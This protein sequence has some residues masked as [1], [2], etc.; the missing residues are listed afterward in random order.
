MSGVHKVQ[1]SITLPRG[2]WLPHAAASRVPCFQGL[3]LASQNVVSLFDS[4]VRV[5]TILTGVAFGAPRHHGFI[6]YSVRPEV[7]EFHFICK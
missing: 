3:T 6:I 7:F 5:I 1:K 2:M 4:R